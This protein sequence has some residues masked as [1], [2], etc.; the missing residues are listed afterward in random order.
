M[1]AKIRKPERLAKN[2][3]RTFIPERQYLGELLKYAAAGGAYEKQKIADATGVPT[4][5]SSGKAIP[6]AD[7]CRGMG[8]VSLVKPASKGM[9]T[10]LSLTPF[11][12][13]VFLEDKFFKEPFSQWL[14][15]CFLCNEW[16]GADVW[17]HLFC[18]GAQVFGNR[19]AKDDVMKWISP[20][21]GGKNPDK[22][23][24]PTFRMY[25][26]EAS[27]GA[28]AAIASV[29]EMGGDVLVRT[30]APIRDEYAVGYAA[31]LVT[32]L[33]RGG[34]EGGQVT[35]D[36]LEEQAGFKRIAGWSLPDSQRVLDLLERKR[37]AEVDRHMHPWIVRF[38]LPS[39]TLWTR[40]FEGFL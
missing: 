18:E 25:A 4:G 2:F 9:D 8:L 17:F 16:S 10:T 21:I 31:W 6:T 23:A 32:C 13:A 5:D 11:G 30:P 24:S 22:A 26:E 28:C 38:L 1:G 36:K 34:Y 40:L 7:Y 3:H 39:T 37:L 19:A 33:E 14:A 27:F 29:K 20:L 15:H 12:R 35:V